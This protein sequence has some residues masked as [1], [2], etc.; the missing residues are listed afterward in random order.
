MWEYKNTD[1]S[2]EIIPEGSIGFVSKITNLSNDKIYYGRKMLSMSSRKVV[3]GKSKKIRKT[4]N[5]QSYFGSCKELL[6]D[7]KTLG[8]DNFKREILMFVK[9][10]ACL[11]LAEEYILHITGALFNQNCYN[12]NIRAKIYRSWFLKTPT[13]FEELQK[14]KL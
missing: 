6:D 5:W 7:V 12:N 9:T 8:E 3:K 14:V 11:T 13:F 1:V 4:S 10:K 2:D